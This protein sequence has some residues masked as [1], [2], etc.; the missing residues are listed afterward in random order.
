MK[1]NTVPGEKNA[2][3]SF[4][5]GKG[6]KYTPERN[7][8]IE[9]ISSFA[10]HFDAEDLCDRLRESD[11]RV[12][13]ATVYRSLPLLVQSGIIKETVHSLE[14][15]S[16]E[17]VLGKEHHD[18]LVCIRCGKYIEFRN[19]EIERLQN[20]VCSQYGFEPSDHLM[21][22]RGFCEQCRRKK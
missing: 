5:K 4:I 2:F 15:T 11:E 16:Y 8:I 13:R 18:H 6:F 17:V 9:A 10:G 14:K 3:Y 20:K 12:S 21:S 22:V 19:D 7:A 1:R